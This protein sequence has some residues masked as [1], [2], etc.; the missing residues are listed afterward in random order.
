MK[1]DRNAGL[2]PAA[3]QEP[4]GSTIV[5]VWHREYWDRVIRDDKHLRVVIEYIH[6]NPVKAGLVDRIELWPWSS[7]SYQ[8]NAR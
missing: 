7:A 5:P 3:R 1:D 6:N 2:Q 8:C 4:G